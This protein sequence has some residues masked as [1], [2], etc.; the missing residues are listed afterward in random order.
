MI[1][2]VPSIPS[3]TLL[4]FSVNPVRVVEA[5]FR[6]TAAPANVTHAGNRA[7]KPFGRDVWL[8]SGDVRG[9]VLYA[10]VRSADLR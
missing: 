5:M 2:S 4:A 3:A 7:R 8:L 1:P 6:M 9:A 10:A